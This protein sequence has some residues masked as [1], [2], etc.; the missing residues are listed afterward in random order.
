MLSDEFCQH[1]R[2]IFEKIGLGASNLESALVQVMARCLPATSHYLSQ[3]WPR[4]IASYDITSPQWV[5]VSVSIYYNIIIWGLNSLR[6]R[7][8]RRYNADNIFKCIFFKEN[9]WIQMKISLKF[10]PDGPPI[11]SIPAL[12]QIMAWRRPGDKPLS[13][14]MMVSLLADM[15]HSASMS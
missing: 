13:E 14:P 1:I 2:C 10:V 5:N 12:V 9:V 8:N 6:S 15:H 4:Y 3:C 7:R 11:T